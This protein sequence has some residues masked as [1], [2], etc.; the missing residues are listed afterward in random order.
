MENVNFLDLAYI[1]FYNLIFYNPGEI[2]LLDQIVLSPPTPPHGFN[3]ETTDRGTA[4][5]K[6][7][8][9]CNIE[10]SLDV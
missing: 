5:Q 8:S 7:G 4:E 6:T 3:K 10:Y 9:K 1:I 2:K